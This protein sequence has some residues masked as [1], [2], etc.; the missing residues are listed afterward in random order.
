MDTFNSFFQTSKNFIYDNTN[1]LFVLL[2]VCVFFY[3][4]S[5]YFLNDTSNKQE[6]YVGYGGAPNENVTVDLT[7][8]KL[9]TCNAEFNKFAKSIAESTLGIEFLINGLPILVIISS[10]FSFI[11]CFITF[12]IGIYLLL[13]R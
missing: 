1:I 6:K 10:I 11:G 7:G 8:E 5:V 13:K 4:A 2:L 12:M 9:T 3:F